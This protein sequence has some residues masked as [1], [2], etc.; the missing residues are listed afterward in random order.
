[1]QTRAK[2]AK[3][4]QMCPRPCGYCPAI[5]FV[6]HVNCSGLAPLCREQ[7]RSVRSM[8]LLPCWTDLKSLVQPLAPH[9]A[10]QALPTPPQVSHS[11]RP[12]AWHSLQLA[13]HTGCYPACPPAAEGLSICDAA[14][15]ERWW[16]VA[17]CGLLLELRS[18]LP[19]GFRP[20]WP[21]TWGATKCF[22]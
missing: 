21:Q 15:M 20:R 13:L 9:T 17:A 12:H 22:T 18:S 11:H 3:H 4:Q 14:A 16:A 10:Q 7:D 2:P 6:Q 5:S 8:M 1:M 19:T